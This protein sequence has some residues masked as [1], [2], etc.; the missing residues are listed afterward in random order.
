M[1]ADRPAAEIDVAARYPVPLPDPLRGNR[2]PI[3]QD[4]SILGLSRWARSR[5]G[6][7]VFTLSFVLVFVLIFVQLLAALFVP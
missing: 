4:P 5:R 2:P 7:Q 6:S 1:S 3:E